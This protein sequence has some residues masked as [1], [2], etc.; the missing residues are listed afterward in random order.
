MWLSILWRGH[1]YSIDE[2]EDGETLYSVIYTDGDVE[3]MNET[4][5]IQAI[6]FYNDLE[7]GRI[8]EWDVGE[9]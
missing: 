6:T 8:D 9:E 7:S 2:D 5:C 1:V 3:D 4:E